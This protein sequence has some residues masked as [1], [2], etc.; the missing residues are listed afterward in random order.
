MAR[1]PLRILLPVSVLVSLLSPSTGAAQ[2]CPDVPVPAY[3][4]EITSPQAHILGF[5]DLRV[6][7]E[8]ANSYQLQL[9]AESDHILTRQFGSSNNGTPLYYSFIGRPENLG[10]LEEINARQRSLRDPRVT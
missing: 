7:S 1:I 5:P 9:T 4:P 8:Q 3:R 6:T 2:T 10:R